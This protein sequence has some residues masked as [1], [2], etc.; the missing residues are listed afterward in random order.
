MSRKKLVDVFVRQTS[1][2]WI[3][4]TRRSKP[5]TKKCIKGVYNLVLCSVTLGTKKLSSLVLQ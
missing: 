2:Y 1:M 3:P 5:Q 4:Y